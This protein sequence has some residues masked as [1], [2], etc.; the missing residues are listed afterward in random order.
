MIEEPISTKGDLAAATSSR[1]TGDRRISIFVGQPAN[2]LDQPDSV[3]PM[4]GSSLID[5]VNGLS[6]VVAISTLDASKNSLQAVSAYDLPSLLNPRS[7]RMTTNEGSIGVYSDGEGYRINMNTFS[8]ESFATQV[9][10][11]YG[12]V[13]VIGLRTRQVTGF[14]LYTARVQFEQP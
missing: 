2:A 14:G 6:L 10:V 13:A 11:D 1:R 5:L 3:M 9:A 12:L 8:S 7:V 4:F